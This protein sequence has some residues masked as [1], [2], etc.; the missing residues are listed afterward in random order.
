[1]YQNILPTVLTKSCLVTKKE[2]E[3]VILHIT[4][5]AK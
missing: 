5:T 1:M 3:N 2:F 4:Y